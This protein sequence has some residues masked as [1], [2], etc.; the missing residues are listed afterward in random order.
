MSEDQEKHLTRSDRERICSCE[1]NDGQEM[2]TIMVNELRNKHVKKLLNHLGGDAVPPY[3]Q[4]AIKRS[5]SEFAEDIT[6]QKDNEYGH[7]AG[8]NRTS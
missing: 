4:K 5:F 1:S 6:K 2:D 3:L 7:D 8:N